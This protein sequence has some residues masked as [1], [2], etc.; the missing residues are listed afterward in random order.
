MTIS[1]RLHHRTDSGQLG[2]ACEPWRRRLPGSRDAAG[3]SFRPRMLTSPCPSLLQM[4]PLRGLLRLSVL[5]A[6]PLHPEALVLLVGH[7]LPVS[8]TLLHPPP[9]G[10][11]LGHGTFSW[12][13]GPWDFL[14]QSRCVRAGCVTRPASCSVCRKPLPIPTGGGGAAGEGELVFGRRAG[15][16][17]RA[18]AAPLPA[19][20]GAQAEH[21]KESESANPTVKFLL[22]QNLVPTRPALRSAAV[23]TPPRRLLEGPDVSSLSTEAGLK[24][25][26]GDDEVV[27]K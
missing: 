5:R 2:R 4:P 20:D 11:A 16:R 13:H 15:Q 21:L 17:P 7:G 14:A 12:G 10:S 23:V 8:S 19:S 26:M 1:F 22:P 6:G 9:Q 3:P 24:R 18:P 25:E 27:G